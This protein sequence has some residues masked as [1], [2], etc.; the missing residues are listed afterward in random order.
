M[1]AERPD[2]CLDRIEV[3]L[4]LEAIHAR[5]GYD[6]REYVPASISRRVSAALLAS[7]AQHLGELQHRVLRDPDLFANVLADLTVPATAMFRDPDFYRALRQRVVPL[8]STYPRLKMWH[9]GC[10][11]GEEVFSNAILLLEEELFERTTIFA[12]DLSR[13]SLEV[14]KQGLYDDDRIAKFSAD[15][16]ASG[17]RASL[18]AYYT[19]AYGRVAFR[20]QLAKKICF[21][22]HDLVTDDVFGEM[23]VVFCRN[24]LMYFD[25]PLR[26]RVVA[27]LARSLCPG[28][29]LCLG[30]DER[31]P[32]SS[33]APFE[34]F[35]GAPDA[36]PIYRYQGDP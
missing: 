32:D 12:T 13:R 4:L 1:G 21:F 23:N 9:A 26:E 8:L 11:T 27:K 10:A 17:G 22:Q 30:K 3:R 25:A 28:G 2:G 7:G 18:S 16:A 31:L 29:F 19:A 36:L 6:L 20:E 15:Y 14:A 5:Y 34:P 24:V 35:D 33:M